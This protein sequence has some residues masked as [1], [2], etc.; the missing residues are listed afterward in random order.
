[1]TAADADDVV[2]VDSS[3]LDVVAAGFSCRNQKNIPQGRPLPSEVLAP[4]DLPPPEGSE[5]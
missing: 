1:M 2:G 5:F 4:S 3:A